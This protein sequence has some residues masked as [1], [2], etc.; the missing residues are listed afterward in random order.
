MTNPLNVG[1]L[2]A[3]NPE[4]INKRFAELAEICWHEW[5]S[6]YQSARCKRCGVKRT[7]STK[8]SHPD[9]CADPRLVL[10][11]MVENPKWMVQFNELPNCLLLIASMLDKTGK[12]ALKAISFM[13]EKK[14]E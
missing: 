9:F 2:E 11:V 12:L 10:R 4:Q 1:T 13:E 6:R 5:D 7:D 8:H 3:M 14:C